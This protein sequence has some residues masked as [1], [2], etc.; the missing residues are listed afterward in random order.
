MHRIQVT[1]KDGRTPPFDRVAA[2]DGYALALLALGAS[3]VFLQ[4]F[5]P[6]DEF[7]HRGD[8][9][10][11]YFQV[12]ANYPRHGF[13]TFDGVNQ[14]NG[15]QPLWAWLLTAI[16][17]VSHFLGITD[18]VLLARLFVAVTAMAHV[19]SVF[20]LV[21]LLWRTVSFGTAVTAGGALLFSM[22]TVSVHTWGMENSLYALMLIG[23]VSYFRL[24]LDAQPSARHSVVFGFL[25]GLTA[26]A[27]LNAVI[28]VAL[29]I[30]TF[31]VTHYRRLRRRALLLAA[32]AA[33]TAGLTV[34]PYVAWN[35]MTTGHLV[36]VSAAAKAIQTAEY[37]RVPGRET[38]LSARFVSDVVTKNLYVFSDFVTGPLADAFW[39][40]GGRVTFSGDR[41]VG[42]ILLLPL[43]G[44]LA[45]LL[46][47]RAG[48]QLIWA[49]LRALRQFAFVLIFAAANGIISV[50][51]YPGQVGYAMTRWWLVETELVLTVTAAALV[52]AA[53]AHVGR[54]SGL[55]PY[56]QWFW[57]AAIALAA[58]FSLAQTVTFYWNGRYD[59]RD[60]NASWNEHSYRAA[61]W[62]ARC[63][64]AEARVGSWNA[65]VLGY[66]AVQRVTNLDGLI[67][68]HALIPHLRDGTLPEYIRKEDL[69]YLSDAESMMKRARVGELVPVE[70]VYRNYMPLIYQH[71]RIYRILP[72]PGPPPAGDEVL[73]TPPAW[74]G[75]NNGLPR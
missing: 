7:I 70:E 31:V 37:M 17:V 10:Y 65:G 45:V 36:P 39:P 16:G 47:G 49:R 74:C 40:L 6:I 63:A 34:A 25:L 57:R 41:G 72:P 26:L 18:K 22:G 56:G 15:V 69:R 71:Y 59:L 62:L 66:H 67:N 48:R 27:R 28:F 14:T 4:A 38:P 51:L 42:P 68:S 60:W 44:C 55:T 1:S 5:I 32:V 30:A 8:D 9:A 19:A 61:V 3:V 33:A 24:V 29:A 35:Y 50:A 11:Y 75:D 13:W 21:H 52:A 12:A 43:T 73:A 23:S 53:I 20:L 64:P 58:V 54:L 46:V 2:R